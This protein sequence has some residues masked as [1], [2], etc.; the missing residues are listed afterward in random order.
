[1]VIET[2][3][4]VIQKILISFLMG[5]LIGLE[6]ESRGA[7]RFMIAGVR[8][9]PIISI[10]GTASVIISQELNDSFIVGIGLMFA[11]AMSIIIAY[12]HY[13]L[14]VPGLTTSAI[15]FATY[16][17]GVIVGLGHIEIA[18]VITVMV[19]LLGLERQ[20]FKHIAESV[21]QTELIEA[22]E[23]IVI[24][25]IIFPLLPEDKI[26]G[27]IDLRW[28]FYI[29]IVISIISF[30]S[31][32]AMR[33]VG[34]RRGTIFSALLGG[35]VNSEATTTSLLIRTKGE[36][37]LRGLITSAICVTNTT[38]LV[39]N[40]IIATL[41]VA[42]FSKFIEHYTVLLLPSIWASLVISYYYSKKIERDIRVTPEIESPLGLKNAV[43]FSLIFFAIYLVTYFISTYLAEAVYIIAIGG[44]VSAAAVISSVAVMTANG[45]LAFKSGV[46]TAVIATLIS[47][48][49]KIIYTYI[50]EKEFTK[51][52]AIAIIFGVMP[53]IAVLFIYYFL[54]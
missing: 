38:M 14:G 44:L 31:F 20:F 45:V 40:I 37:K 46:I 47:Y 39:R 17:I 51:D 19:V 26:Y 18:A 1:M 7:K 10:A 5:F 30:I 52:V 4:G 21:S 22:L 53:S 15:A 49:D 28:L 12:V 24:A 32:V 8:T 27:F 41:S 50:I 48:T 11:L 36:K 42:S 6:R 3:V 29:I 43:K 23:F 34:L 2:T 9:F 35:L 33:V 54:F 13:S 16:L 25:L